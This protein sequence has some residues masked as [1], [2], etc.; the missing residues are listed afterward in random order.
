MVDKAVAEGFKVKFVCKTYG[1][2][3]S[4][5]YAW[6]KSKTG[7]KIEVD[8][9]LAA[10]IVEIHRVSRGTYGVPRVVAK[11]KS[12]GEFFGK[13]RVGRL[14]KAEGLSGI[15]KSKFRVATTDSNHSNPVAERVFKIE[16][17]ETQ[18]TRPHQV[19]VSDITYIP[20]DEG[21]L[22]LAIVMDLFSRML[23]GFS[24]SKH[25]RASLIINALGMALG[26]SDRKTGNA[27]IGHSDRGSQYASA[28]YREF[29]EKSD[30]KASMSR[31]GNCYDN[32][33]AESFFHTLKVEL[34]HR[35]RFRTRQEAINA[36]F[37]YIEVWYNR[38]RIHSALG[39]KTPLEYEKEYSK[40]NRLAA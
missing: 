8:K 10:K 34:V 39:F 31:S 14:M 11:L 38:Q 30:I 28:E 16:T 21:W 32:A 12:E 36:I 3:R 33:Y 26:R 20:T 27:L 18:V 22:Y 2:L 5:Y 17:V 1:L 40:L 15:A 4:S 13:K 37:E 6:K 23:L 7:V 24:M 35:R 9:R 29:L 25:M 19:W